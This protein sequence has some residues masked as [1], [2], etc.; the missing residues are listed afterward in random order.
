V[1]PFP[2]GI[3]PDLES[4]AGPLFCRVL[5]A[6]GVTATE[7]NNDEYGAEDAVAAANFAAAVVA[8]MIRCAPSRR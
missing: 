8:E 5:C 1:N 7:G 2:E 4:T 3:A 6:T